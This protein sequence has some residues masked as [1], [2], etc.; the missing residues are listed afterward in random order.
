MNNGYVS[1]FTGAG[2][3]D[4]GLE[5]S[6]L[7]T[8]SICE[9]EKVFCNTLE[10]NR[11]WV[12]SDKHSY[13]KAAKIIN[14]DIRELRPR[15][16]HADGKIN[17]VVGGPPCQAFSSAGKQLSVLDPRGALVTE[18]CRIVDSLKPRMFLF[19][20][21]RGLV[22]ARDK[23]GE[24]GG[25][26]VELISILE[27][28]GYSCRAG[29]LNSADYGSYQRRVR[30]FIL[31]SRNGVAP[32]F[33]EPKFEKEG[34][35]FGGRWRSLGNF[36][37]RYSDSNKAN[38]SYP[39]GVLARQL[40]D[41]PDGSGLKSPGKTEN[42]RPG[43]HWGYRQGTFIA[44]K[45]LPARTVTGSA[46]QDWV[47]HK[48]VLRR[49][50][51]N[52]IKRLQ[53]FPDDWIVEGTKAQQYKQIGNAVPSIFGEML[54]H[55]ILRH[56]ADFPKTKPVRLGVPDS[57]KG[58]IEYTKRDHARNKESRAIHRHFEK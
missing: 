21:V 56:L 18:F 2:G 24:P 29:L 6:G 43:G 35:L 42:T 20:N 54:G 11:G 16:L 7:E 3:L 52:E 12:H 51:F 36:L 55:I 38:F 48:G 31:G 15:D 25:V 28:L 39:T 8:V 13:L 40:K 14:A 1:L 22:T 34:G 19:E 4:I 44:D 23:S 47:R 5:R 50:T 37:E 26:I 27:G 57:F 17:L 10:K 58:H 9:I 30:C 49:L 41:I 53:G 33:P 32:H 45:N 46:S